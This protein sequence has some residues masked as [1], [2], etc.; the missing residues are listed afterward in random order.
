MPD[1]ID[2]PAVAQSALAAW[3]TWSRR[4]H[5]PPWSELPGHDQE[6]WIDAILVGISTD[7]QVSW[8]EAQRALDRE[9]G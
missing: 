1:A 6:A 7:E 3:D 9:G 8:A 4:T 2:W 5:K